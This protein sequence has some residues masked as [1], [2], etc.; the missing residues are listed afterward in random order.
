MGFASGRG[1]VGLDDCLG[2]NGTEKMKTKE[3]EKTLRNNFVPEKY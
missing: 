2:S 3:Y 1:S